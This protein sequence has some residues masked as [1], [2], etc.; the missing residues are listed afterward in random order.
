[1]DVCT[2][3]RGSPFVLVSMVVVGLLAYNPSP[4]ILGLSDATALQMWMSAQLLLF[5][6]ISTQISCLW[7]N[8]N[9][10]MDWW[11]FFRTIYNGGIAISITFISAKCETVSCPISQLRVFSGVVSRC[12][13]RIIIPARF[14]SVPFTS[15]TVALC[16]WCGAVCG[17]GRVQ[18]ESPNSKV[19]LVLCTSKFPILLVLSVLWIPEK[20]QIHVWHKLWTDT[21]HA[22]QWKIVPLLLMHSHPHTTTDDKRPLPIRRTRNGWLHW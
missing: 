3:F 1:M 16:G 5:H 10:W 14:F 20:T 9:N 6:R 13:T 15:C 12:W 22:T 18:K 17:M 7:Q 19:R 11:L 21:K 4:R 8:K 2:P